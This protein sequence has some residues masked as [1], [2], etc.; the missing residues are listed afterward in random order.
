MGGGI[1]LQI[2]TIHLRGC[3]HVSFHQDCD[4]TDDPWPSFM[5]F[6]AFP[7]HMLSGF[8]GFLAEYASGIDCVLIK[9]C[10]IG[11]KCDGV[12]EESGPYAGSLNLVMCVC[13]RTIMGVVVLVATVWHPASTGVTRTRQSS[14]GADGSLTLSM[15]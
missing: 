6:Q 9:F 11:L 10:Q 2:N 1:Q 14:Q 8:W 12:G 13:R 4:P 7:Q 5:E 15:Y 3:H